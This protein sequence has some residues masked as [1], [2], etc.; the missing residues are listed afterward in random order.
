[1]P[2]AHIVRGHISGAIGRGAKLHGTDYREQGAPRPHGPTRTACG[3]GGAIPLAVAAGT[4]AVF[5]PTLGNGFVNWDD[6]QTL[7]DNPHYRGLGWTQ[8]RWGLTT[9]LMGDYSPLARVP[10][11]AG[12][13]PSGGDPPRYHFPRP[14]P[15]R[16]H[17]GALLLRCATVV[18]GRGAG[19]GGCGAGDEAVRGG[20]GVVVRHPPAP[21][22]IGG[23]GVGPAGRFVRGFLPR[24][25]ARG[26]EGRGD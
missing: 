7:V 15:A 24:P 13:F 17:G 26:S 21:G 3:G 6:P 23:L 8:L 16:R 20:G 10:L 14:A 11:A 5:A 22:G 4:A 9:F 19:R 18:A 2:A 1:M 25:G 12:Y